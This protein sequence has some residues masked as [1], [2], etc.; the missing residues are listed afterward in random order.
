MISHFLNSFFRFQI[1]SSHSTHP[2]IVLITQIFTK[3]K[4][5]C[6]RIKGNVVL[7]LSSRSE[8]D[9]CFLFT[10]QL[11]FDF[12]HVLP[13]TLQ[14]SKAVAMTVKPEGNLESSWRVCLP[15]CVC[16]YL[17]C[18]FVITEDLQRFWTNDK[19]ALANRIPASHCLEKTFITFCHQG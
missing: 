1:Q 19:L 10:R 9:W 16:L 8:G 11:L 6:N 13:K 7:P 12:K 14:E 17:I 2:F 15:F 18:A 4:V 5:C 3:Q